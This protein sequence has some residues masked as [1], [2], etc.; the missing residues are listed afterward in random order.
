[1]TPAHAAAF[2]ALATLGLLTAAEPAR[3]CIWNV[4]HG[5]NPMPPCEMDDLPGRR[6]LHQLNTQLIGTMTTATYHIREV[7]RE[8]LQWRRTIQQA[9]RYK[10]RME[11]YY[12]NL[13]ANPLP[14]MVAAY[15]RD[16]PLA[17]YFH[18]TIDGEFKLSLEP[19]NLFASADSLIRSFSDSL[20]VRKQ[21]FDI[22]TSRL[23][24]DT[25]DRRQWLQVRALDRLNRVVDHRQYVEVVSDSLRRTGEEL[26]LR[27]ADEAEAAGYAEARITRLSASLSRLHG[28]ALDTEVRALQARMQSYTGATD[29]M[30]RIETLST[31]RAPKRP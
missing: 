13:T 29:K 4:E 15:N 18:L 20:T 9:Q 27:Y 1:M 23:E 28:T 31:L 25:E 26:A 3:A 2:V 24:R 22:F 12:G 10:Q 11:L 21:Y 14:S 16:S 7:R 8:I 19:V 5:G 17:A 30:D 6:R